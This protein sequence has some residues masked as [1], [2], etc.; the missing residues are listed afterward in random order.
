MNIVNIE[1]ENLHIF[2]MTW[3]ISVK[4][5]GKMTSHKKS[6]LYP[7]SEIFVFGKTTGGNLRIL[8][9]KYPKF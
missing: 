9:V 1:E 3:G 6:G 7:L 5:S 4:F 2:W 8:R